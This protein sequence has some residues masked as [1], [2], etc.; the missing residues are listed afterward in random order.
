MKDKTLWHQTKIESEIDKNGSQVVKKIIEEPIVKKHQFLGMEPKD[1]VDAGVKIAGLIAIVIS[2]LSYVRSVD[3]ERKDDLSA[4]IAKQQKQIEDRDQKL[5][6]I[7]REKKSDEVL[8]KQLKLKQ[9]EVLNSQLSSENDL[10]QRQDALNKTLKSSLEG[11]QLNRKIELDKEN[12]LLQLQTYIPVITDITRLT[13]TELPF[14][15]SQDAIDQ[16]RNE[17]YP[18]I[19]LINNKDVVN[20]F[21]STMKLLDNYVKNKRNE[22]LLDSVHYQ[23][24][25]LFFQNYSEVPGINGD[26][27]ATIARGD[28]LKLMRHA[29]LIVDLLFRANDEFKQQFITNNT[30]VEEQDYSILRRQIEIN[31]LESFVLNLLET[32][33][34]KNNINKKFN[35]EVDN[36]VIDDNYFLFYKVNLSN[37]VNL[38]DQMRNLVYK[39]EVKTKQLLIKNTTKLEELMT[40]NNSILKSN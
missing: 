14:E 9:A 40:N 5:R 1:L 4:Q 34:T 39:T 11:I 24:L 18:K 28:S 3:K 29:K 2:I 25:L 20:Q 8:D 33:T 16:L 21:N 26:R 23:L 35:L 30:I 38:I 27:V 7:E 36:F 13:N 37:W 32:L 22:K 6:D 19:V 31:D 17:Y 12:S 10:A 15:K